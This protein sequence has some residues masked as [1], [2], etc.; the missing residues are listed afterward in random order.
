MWEGDGTAVAPIAAGQDNFQMVHDGF[1]GVIVVWEDSRDGPGMQKIYMQRINVNGDQVWGP[2]GSRICEVES[3]QANPEVIW[4]RLNGFFVVWEDNR[5]GANEIDLY[6]RH[7]NLAG[8]MNWTGLGI[9][10]ARVNGPQ[11]N[12]RLTTTD[13]NGVA[14]IWEDFR[15]GLY[16]NLYAQKM[17]RKGVASWQTNGLDIFAGVMENQHEADLVADGFGG[18]VFVYQKFSEKTSGFDLF[19]GRILSSGELAWHFATCEAPENQIKP[20]MVK[21]GSDLII[22]WEDERN[23]NSDIYSQMIAIHSGEFKWLR[24]GRPVCTVAD[25]DKAVM[26]VSTITSNTQIFIWERTEADGTHLY[27]QKLD[28]YGNIQWDAAGMRLSTSPA[29]QSE[30]DACTDDESGVVVVWADSREMNSSGIFFQRLNPNGLPLVSK[31]GVKLESDHQHAYASLSGLNLLPS[32][33]GDF[34]LVWEDGRNGTGNKDIYMQK[35]TGSGE[36]LWRS[37]G[38]AVC[39]APGNQER[40]IIAE[41]GVGGIFAIWIDY[42]DNDADAYIY[43]QRIDPQGMR[44]WKAGGVPVTR[45]QK[46]KS[47]IRLISDGKEGLVTCWVDT[48]HYSLTGFDLYVQRLNHLGV[49][50]WGENGKPLTREEGLQSSPTLVPDGDG[51]AIIAWM[52]DRSGFANIF[53][54]HLNSYG[55]QEWEAGGRRINSVSCHQRSPQLER[56]FRGDIYLAWE[57]GCAGDGNEKIMISLMTASGIKL[58]G[59]S[60]K[61]ASRTYGRQTKPRLRV[62]ADGNAFVTWLDERSGNP[63]DLKMYSQ[64]FN[65]GGDPLWYTD[66]VPIG[67]Q[68]A[69]NNDFEM[70]LNPGGYSYFFWNATGN[71]A[72]SKRVFY[73]KLRP[74]GLKKL[75]LDGMEIGD[76]TLDQHYPVMSINNESRVLVCWVSIDPVTG[77]QRLDGTLIPGQ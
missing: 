15:N 67:K 19:R 20:R 70:I 4:D 44:Q 41:D 65:I 14:M 60:G 62:D 51:G 24:D 21:K 13:E 63:E 50:M 77:T 12:V 38:I 35:L 11:R 58:W 74:D 55:I 31:K 45:A 66:G 6:I 29:Q 28:N 7:I 57:D 39:T 22:A 9:A 71:G 30:P 69:M 59:E 72:G 10:V 43:S 40:P 52:D 42:R 36:P 37:G 61:F 46:S 1:G 16:W 32:L 68:M 48:R 54:Q 76:G 33:S 8:K 18:F 75:N 23:Q 64:K 56:N 53:M 2:S 26:L 27:S 34:F 73:Q 5:N 47:N 49:A 3:R 17:D 25:D